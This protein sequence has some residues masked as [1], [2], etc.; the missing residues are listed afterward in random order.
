MKKDGPVRFKVRYGFDKLS[1]LSVE[2]GPELEKAIY[3]WVEQIPVTIGGKM[4][5]G[6]HIISIEGDFHYY[7]GWYETYLP[8]SGDDF[9]QIERDCPKFEGYV[10][11]YRQRVMHLIGNQQTHLIGTLPAIEPK[12]FK[13][14]KGGSSFAR[15]L[16]VSKTN[17]NEAGH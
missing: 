10:D 14:L 3:A 15:Q 1:T 9:A 13:A 8:T 12:A 2:A 6:K 7:T 5:Q 17:N 11:A 4:I 16:L